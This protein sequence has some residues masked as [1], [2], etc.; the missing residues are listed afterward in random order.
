MIIDILTLVGVLFI[1]AGCGI[2]SV[3]GFVYAVE[4]LQNGGSE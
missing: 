4:R 2:A 1:G 3:V